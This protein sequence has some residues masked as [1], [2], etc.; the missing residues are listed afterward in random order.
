[1]ARGLAHKASIS[2]CSPAFY[3]DGLGGIIVP[4]AISMAARGRHATVCN[5]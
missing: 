3:V 1:M 5:R 2:V 4:H